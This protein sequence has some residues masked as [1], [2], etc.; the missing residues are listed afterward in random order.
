MNPNQISLLSFHHR[1][2]SRVEAMCVQVDATVSW[3]D[4]R[5]IDLILFLSS[6]MHTYIVDLANCDRSFLQDTGI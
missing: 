3:H 1:P 5:L 2:E 4:N 6:L